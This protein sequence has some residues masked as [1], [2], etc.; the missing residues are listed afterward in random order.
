EKQKYKY[1]PRT[2][3]G[4]LH[5]GSEKINQK[6]GNTEIKEALNIRKDRVDSADSEIIDKLIKEC[7]RVCMELLRAYAACLEIDS[8]SGGDLYFSNRHRYDKVS[9]DVLR[10][11]FYPACNE[12]DSQTIR[13]DG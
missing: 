1:I 12:Q 4:W 13:A 6:S 3:A 11:L 7:H 2:N 5:V 10:S 8:S 9:G